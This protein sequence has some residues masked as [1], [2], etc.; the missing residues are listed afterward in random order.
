[1][2]SHQTVFK[3]SP[4]HRRH[5]HRLPE[6][7]Y[8]TPGY[9]YVTLCTQ[10]RK[11]HF[12]K[13]ANGEMHLNNMGFLIREVWASLPTRYMGL[14]LDEYIIMPNHMHGIIVLSDVYPHQGQIENKEWK[15]PSLSKIIRTFKWASA[16]QVHAQITEKFTWQSDFYDHIV[17]NEVDLERIRRYIIDNP[18]RWMEDTYY[19]REGM[20]S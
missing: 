13:V 7:D 9:Y 16:Y 18:V 15:T 5:S 20:L 14:S 3:P 2:T 10:G 19:S 11:S 8:S 4:G 12:G 1:M 17:R 6:Y